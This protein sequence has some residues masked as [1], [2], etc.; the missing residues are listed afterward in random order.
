LSRRRFTG[1]TANSSSHS[2]FC[3]PRYLDSME[4]S[5]SPAGGTGMMIWPLRS[6][7]ARL[8]FLK[9]VCAVAEGADVPLSHAVPDASSSHCPP[10]VCV[11][12][13]L[14]DALRRSAAC[15]TNTLSKRNS[16]RT[17]VGM[18]D[19][20][21]AMKQQSALDEG[22]IKLLKAYVS[23][24]CRARPPLASPPPLPPRPR[25]HFELRCRRPAVP[26][27]RAPR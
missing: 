19:E 5:R 27:G 9:A 16:P 8:L 4:E 3:T 12:A 7:T 24:A 25:P 20:P 21:E 11:G 6:S 23:G 17:S 18:H 10:D 22:D 15:T 13:V 2:Q 1:W 26:V 14:G